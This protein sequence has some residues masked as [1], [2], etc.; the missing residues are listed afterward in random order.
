MLEAMAMAKPIIT[1]DSI[2]CR[3][4]IEDG[5]N[6]FMVPVK[7]A[8][9]VAKAMMRM[10]AVGEEERREMGRYGRK[11]AAREFDER[12]VIQKYLEVIEKLLPKT[13][14]T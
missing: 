10:I 6:G 12:L 8:A 9:A 4:V 5:K 7:D 1:T 13:G 11:K 3:E 2:G 14:E